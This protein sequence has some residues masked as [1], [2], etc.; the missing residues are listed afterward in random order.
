M[1][2][3]KL[4]KSSV[5]YEQAEMEARYAGYEVVGRT[6]SQRGEYLVFA[7]P[8]TTRHWL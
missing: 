2:E 6:M 3:K 4:F 8:A 5:S 1:V 7:R